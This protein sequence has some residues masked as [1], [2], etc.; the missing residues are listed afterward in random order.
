MQ[1][2]D[3]MLRDNEFATEP[4][5]RLLHGRCPTV[6][7][8][9]SSFSVGYAS[10]SFNSNITSS[11]PLASC[12]GSGAQRRSVAKTV[13][14]LVVGHSLQK[15]ANQDW[16]QPLQ[17]R[18]EG[19][20]TPPLMLE[21]RALQVPFPNRKLNSFFPINYLRSYVLNVQAFR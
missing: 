17:D 4:S 19:N 12:N 2:L 1:E 15:R 8:G 3:S 18:G 11:V 10:D 6:L 14:R 13:C 5:G 21:N 20:N 9:L 16:P 7:L